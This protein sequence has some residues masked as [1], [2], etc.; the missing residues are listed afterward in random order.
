M[1]DEPERLRDKLKT[2]SQL[3]RNPRCVIFNHFQ[4]TKMSNA[5]FKFILQLQQLH[6]LKAMKNKSVL[7]NVLLALTAKMCNFCNFIKALL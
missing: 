4:E 2:I 1:V 3:M 5:T 6:S 7:K